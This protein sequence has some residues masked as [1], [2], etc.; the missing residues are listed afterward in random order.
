M[1]RQEN[2]T[3]ELRF[4]EGRF[5]TILYAHGTYE[6]TLSFGKFQSSVTAAANCYFLLPVLPQNPFSSPRPSFDGI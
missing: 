5:E 3:T 2:P 4:V 6:A 1:V